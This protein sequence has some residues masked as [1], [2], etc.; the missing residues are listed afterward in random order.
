MKQISRMNAIDGGN[1][2]QL[3]TQTSQAEKLGMGPKTR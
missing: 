1:L 2:Q 3:N